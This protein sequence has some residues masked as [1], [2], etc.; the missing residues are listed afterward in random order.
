MDINKTIQIDGT[1]WEFEVWAEG[2]C[3]R[4]TQGGIRITAEFDHAVEQLFWDCYS[5][6]D[7]EETSGTLS[8][9]EW[10]RAPREDLARCL[11]AQRRNG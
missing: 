7:D 1:N 2:D 3:V 5:E 8:F 9:F 10:I 11:V 4:L 6:E